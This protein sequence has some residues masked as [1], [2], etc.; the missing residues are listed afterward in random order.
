MLEGAA[1]GFV[2]DVLVG[3]GCEFGDDVVTLLATNEEATKRAEIANSFTGRVVFGAGKF[4][5]GECGEVGAVTFAG[6]V[7]W[8]AFLAEGCQKGLEAGNDGANGGD[9]VALV[10]EVTFLGAKIVLHVNYNQGCCLGIESAVMRPKI[11]HSI[12]LET[13]IAVVMERSWFS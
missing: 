13:H 1:A 10:D 4:A 6:V 7:D 5:R 9:I 11:W 12:N 8:E 2:N 3:E